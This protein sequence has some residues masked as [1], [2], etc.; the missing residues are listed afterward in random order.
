MKV[1]LPDSPVPVHRE[2]ESLREKVRQCESL[3]GKV[4][5]W[6]RTWEC[7]CITVLLCCQSSESI[8]YN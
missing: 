6:E 7:N 8:G 2:S 4:R 1:L 5:V 3:R